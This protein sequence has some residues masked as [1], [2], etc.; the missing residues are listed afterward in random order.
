MKL[1]NNDVALTNIQWKNITRDDYIDYI[2]ESALPRA[3]TTS[4]T[5]AAQPLL[6]AYKKGVKRD[7]LKPIIIMLALL[8]CLKLW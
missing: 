3:T 2:T 7:L 4:T 6:T 8:I 5:V 1:K